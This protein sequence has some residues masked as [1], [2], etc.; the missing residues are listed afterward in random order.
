MII[1]VSLAAITIFLGYLLV[2]GSAMG[3]TLALTS[4]APHFV[5]CNHCLRGG[6][7]WVY[8]GIWLACTTA[9]AFCAASIGDRGWAWMEGLMLVGV[10]IT[11]LWRNIWEARQRGL[12]HQ[13]LLTALTPV[14]V[15]LGYL[16]RY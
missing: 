12:A 5:E 16:L 15:S 10:L 4:A 7:K 14:G 11:V 2:V 8:A 3:M 9:G 6:Y 13:I 1:P